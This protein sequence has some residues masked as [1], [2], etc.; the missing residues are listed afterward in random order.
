MGRRRPALSATLLAAA[1]LLML[2]EALPVTAGTVV[3]RVVFRDEAPALTPVDVAKDREICGDSVP[4]EAL[5]V[6]PRTRGVRSTVVS[7][8]GAAPASG[9]E[10]REATLENRRCRFVPHVTAI[11]V[12]AEL[13]IVNADSVLHNLRAWTEDDP[14]RQVF[15]VV[16]PSQG[17][18]TKRSIKRSGVITLTCDTH[19]HMSGYLLAFDH[20]YFAVT[21]EEGEFRIEHVPAGTYRVSVWHEG[22]AVVRRTAEGRLVYGPAHQL[23]REVTVPETGTVRVTFEL[24]R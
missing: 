1:A 19:V 3:G 7:V 8:E 10:L 18:V 9:S 20:P 24:G 6:S 13:A 14:R 5:A 11:Q 17:Q 2:V 21:D 15:N 12:G 22:W 4:S 16:Q 23:S